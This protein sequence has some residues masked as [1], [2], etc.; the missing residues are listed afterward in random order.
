VLFTKMELR[1]NDDVRTMFSIFPRYM[2][3]GPI[4]LDATLVRSVEDICANMIHP[5]MVE[6]GEG[7]VEEVNLSDP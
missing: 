2:T 4:E 6:P 5:S 7:E 3:K 1:N